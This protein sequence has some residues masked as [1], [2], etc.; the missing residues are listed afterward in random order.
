MR[1]SCHILDGMISIYEVLEIWYSL[2]WS[3]YERS[4]DFFYSGRVFLL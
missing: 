1:F 2:M 3:E 4:S